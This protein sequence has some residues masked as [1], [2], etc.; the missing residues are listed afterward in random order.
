MLWAYFSARGPWYLVHMG[1]WILSNT[2]RLKIKT[3]FQKKFYNGPSYLSTGK[4]SKNKNK[5]WAIDHKSKLLPWLSQSSELNSIDKEWGELKR[6]T[7]MD[8]EWSLISCLVFFN[9]FRHYRWKPGKLR[10]RKVFNKMVSRNKNFY[11][12]IFLLFYFSER[13]TFFFF[14]IF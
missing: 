7:S 4:W 5:K 8:L 6:S 11:F 14:W 2:N 9:L 10:F 13:I 12:I 3:C 1:W